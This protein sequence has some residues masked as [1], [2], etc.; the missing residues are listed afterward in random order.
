MKTIFD[1]S[2][3]QGNKPKVRWLGQNK[4]QLKNEAWAKK[5]RHFDTLPQNWSQT[6]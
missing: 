6:M 3:T 5:H 2:G 1:E 4:K